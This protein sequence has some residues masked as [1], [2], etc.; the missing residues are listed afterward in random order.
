MITIIASLTL[1]TLPG[2]VIGVGVSYLIERIHLATIDDTYTRVKHITAAARLV[3]GS[4]P[5]FAGTQ[6]DIKH[7]A[8]KTCLSA[9][10]S[11]PPIQNTY[12]KSLSILRKATKPVWRPS[13]YRVTG[14]AL[15]A[16]ANAVEAL[17]ELQQ[18]ARRGDEDWNERQR[19]AI[20]LID[21]HTP[22]LSARLKLKSV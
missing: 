3:R 17:F 5:L 20:E 13:K 22:P 16:H 11:G 10:A 2:W 8:V 21:A 12:N 14:I 4:A 1:F 6:V 18:A 7:D 9:Y 19:H 15:V